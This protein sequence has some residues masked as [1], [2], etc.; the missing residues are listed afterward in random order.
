MKQV[1]KHCVVTA[2]AG[3]TTAIEIWKDI[4]VPGSNYKFLQA[5]NPYHRFVSIFTFRFAM[6]NGNRAARASIDPNDYDAREKEDLRQQVRSSFMIRNPEQGTRNES[7]RSFFYNVIKIH[8]ADKQSD[9]HIRLQTVPTIPVDDIIFLHKLP[10][11]YLIPASKLGI[12]LDISKVPEMMVTNKRDDVDWSEYSVPDITV[13]EWWDFGGTPSDYG[14]FYDDELLDEVY[15]YYKQDFD[16]LG[17]R[18]G[19]L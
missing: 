13:E 16:F 4:D 5:R 12:D 6:V 15:E 11:A 7:F 9:D 17:I 19:E 8:D 3:S 18:K 14:L 1:A 10:E 2:K